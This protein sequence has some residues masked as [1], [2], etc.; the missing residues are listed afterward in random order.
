MIHQDRLQKLL[1]YDP[2]TGLFTWLVRT[3]KRIKIGAAAGSPH[4]EGYRQIKIDG[5][6][7]L[8]HRLAWL[9]MTGD[10]PAHQLDHINGIRDDNRWDNLREATQAENNQNM[11]MHRDNTSGFMGVCWHRLAGKWMAQIRV[12]GRSRYLGLFTTPEAAHEA[13][14]AAKSELHTFQPIPRPSNDGGA[15]KWNV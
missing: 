12:A 1:D 13:Y 5:E 2:D 11:A 14:V 9:W 3:N 7:H 4:N 6:K 15:V 10:W 8:A